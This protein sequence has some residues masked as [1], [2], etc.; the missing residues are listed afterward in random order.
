MRTTTIIQ[1]TQQSSQNVRQVGYGETGGREDEVEKIMRIFIVPLRCERF[2]K[3][4]DK[5]EDTYTTNY[6]NHQELQKTSCTNQSKSIQ[7]CKSNQS[8]RLECG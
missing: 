1:V 4:E 5:R 8:S 7:S 2:S 6:I 3:R